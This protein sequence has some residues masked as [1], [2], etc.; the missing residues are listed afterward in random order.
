MERGDVIFTHAGNIG[1]VAYIPTNSRFKKYVI[2]QRQFYLR[3]KAERII[4]EFVTYFFRSRHGR[5]LLLANTSSVGVPSIA[6]PVTYLRTIEIPV[7]PLA[8]QSAIAKILGTL[9]DKIDL[10]HRM[11]EKLDVIARALFKSWFV[12]FDPVRAKVKGLRLRLPSDAAAC[13]PDRFQSSSLGHIPQGWEIGSVGDLFQLQRGFDLPERERRPGPYPVVTAS[14]PTGTH[15][16]FMAHGPG[17]TT[18]RSGL[19]GGVFFIHGDYWPHNT[20]LWV[21]EFLHSTPAYAYYFLRALDFSVVSTGSA[22]PTLNR[23]HIHSLP[24]ILPPSRL[25]AL[26]EARASTCLLKQEQNL[27]ESRTL[28]SLRDTL[29]PKLIS[30]EIRIKDAERFADGG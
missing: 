12:E 13:F 6:Q 19:I 27:Q 14:G 1:Q 21:K 18:G 28:A 24:A 17:V 10:S 26:F 8:E 7:P 15:D 16:S 25:I 4:P 2:S 11:N 30:G 3:C 20:S 29:L 23:N 5:Q 9:D 22:V